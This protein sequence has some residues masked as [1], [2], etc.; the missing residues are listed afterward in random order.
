MTRSMLLRTRSVV[1]SALLGA[2]LLATACGTT[3]EAEF[4]VAEPAEASAEA[5][6]A[7]SAVVADGDAAWAE[8]IDRAKLEVALAKWEEASKTAPSAEVFVKLARG[9][10]FLADAFYAVEGNEEKRDAHYTLGLGFAEKAIALSAPD[11]VAALKGG[12]KVEAA[13]LKA[14]PEA[15]PSLYWQATN[16]GKWAAS[17]GFATRL[18]YKDDIKATMLHVKSL[19][20]MYFFAGPWRY[21][22]GFEAATAGLAG[23]DLNKSKENF[24]MAIQR[25]PNYLGTK[26]LYADMYA[27]KANDKD[28]YKR[29][30]E[31]VLAADPKAEPEAEPENVREQEKAKG[32]LAKIDDVF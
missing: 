10:Y 25:A 31:E 5:K 14:P 32:L 2:A 3:R 29:L 6:D 27:T 22:G 24:E 12:E 4:E 15:V 30:L 17:K 26:V 19:D 1:T 23:G 28:L 21:F 11:Y 8:R 13:V 20:D 16:L 18:K 7:A 9:H